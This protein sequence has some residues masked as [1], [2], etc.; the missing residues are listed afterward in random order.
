MHTAHGPYLD[1][2]TLSTGSAVPY[3]GLMR[4][5]L[6]RLASHYDY[7]HWGPR[8]RW[9]TLWKG[10]DTTA[11]PFA[12]CAARLAAVPGRA[13]PRARETAVGCEI[14]RFANTQVRMHL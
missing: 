5:P 12:E 1:F 10:Q 7:I 13:T 4:A 11:L 6:E 9:A 3:F 8:S 14:A 2:A